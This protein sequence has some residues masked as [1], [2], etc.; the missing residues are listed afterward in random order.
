VCL[1]H[2]SN[3]MED[4]PALNHEPSDCIYRRCTNHIKQFCVST[5]SFLDITFRVLFYKFNL[6][7]SYPIQLDPRKFEQTL[8]P[9]FPNSNFRIYFFFFVCSVALSVTNKKVGKA[10]LRSWWRT[11]LYGSVVSAATAVISNSCN[12][13]SCL[14]C[15]EKYV[16]NVVSNFNFPP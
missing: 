2:L 16:L 5:L 6:P 7:I 3:I 12:K 8:N 14:Y 9:H 15:E 10:E 13:L 11:R 1:K 4:S